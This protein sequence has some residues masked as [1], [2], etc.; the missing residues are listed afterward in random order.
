MVKDHYKNLGFRLEGDL[1]IMDLANYQ[2][3]Q[4]YIQISNNHGKQ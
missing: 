2:P 4:C 3:K 1:W